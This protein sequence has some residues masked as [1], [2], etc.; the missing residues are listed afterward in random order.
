MIFCSMN[1]SMV[2]RH[3][4]VS[5]LRTCVKIVLDDDA[6]VLYGAVIILVTISILHHKLYKNR[7][8]I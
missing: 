3:S 8:F 6:I 7:V 2:S 4:A 1:A 5:A